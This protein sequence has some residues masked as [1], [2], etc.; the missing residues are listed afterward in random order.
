MVHHAVEHHMGHQVGDHAV[1][2]NVSAVGQ[3]HAV[4]GTAAHIDLFDLG[5]VPDVAAQLADAGIKGQCDFVAALLGDPRMLGQI[6]IG[7]EGV[8]REAHLCG[9]RRDKGP[10]GFKDMLRLFGNA[11]PVKHFVAGNRHH[12]HQVVVFKQHFHLGGRRRLIVV[13]GQPV[14]AVN[15]HTGQ[16]HDGGHGFA[17]AGNGLL[18]F[19][20]ESLHANRHGYIKPALVGGHGGKG[21]MDGDPFYIQLVAVL[22][23]S[24]HSALGTALLAVTHLAHLV[25]R[26]LKFILAASE[27]GS[28]AAGQVVLFNQKR[29]F[30]RQLAL[31]GGRHTGVAGAYHHNIVFGH[32][33]F[34][35]NLFYL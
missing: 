5:V 21:F 15:Q 25:Q 31:Q 27:A 26:R 29:P 12:P 30:S 22:Q 2:G 16:L 19:V 3:H 32:G 20:D 7:H 4:Y 11:D 34:L 14:H 35:L 18:H 9:V 17:G 23:Q 6:H 8:H 33:S 10:V 1:A 13:L 24:A 28:T